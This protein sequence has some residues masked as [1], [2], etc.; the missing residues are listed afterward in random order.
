VGDGS[1]GL[2]MGS[3]KFGPFVGGAESGV[4][5]IVVMMKTMSPMTKMDVLFIILI[6]LFT[7]LCTPT[8]A[9]SKLINF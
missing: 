7:Y 5:A 3:K 8:A 1:I 9:T 6:P 4:A 2:T